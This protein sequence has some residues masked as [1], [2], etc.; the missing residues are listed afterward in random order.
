MATVKEY[1][2]EKLTRL[3][4]QLTDSELDNLLVEVS[5]TGSSTFGGNNV[6]DTKKAMA[7]IIPELLAMPK[8]TEGGYSI[9]QNTDGVLKYYR[10][11]CSELG[12][13]N[14]LEPQPKVKA[15]KLW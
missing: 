13:E 6:A 3:G 1:I 4:F 9:S 11:L 14:K 10:M 5:V 7:A 12:I 2:G 8:V 15:R